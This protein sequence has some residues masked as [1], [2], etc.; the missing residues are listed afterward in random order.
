MDSN[1][2]ICRHEDCGLILEEPVTLLCGN[3]LCKHHLDQCDTKF[4]CNFCHKMHTIPEDGFLV[5]KAFVSIIE[6]YIKL[7]PLKNE[8]KKSFDK[9]S[10]SINDYENLDQDIYVSDYFNNLKQKVNLHKEELIKEITERCEEVIKELKDKQEKCKSS[11]NI[12]K[13]EKFDFYVLKNFILTNLKQKFRAPNMNQ[14]DANELLSIM[15]Q[16]DEQIESHFVK[17]KSDLLLGESIEFKM[18]DKSSSFG[19]LVIFSN[20]DSLSNNCGQLIRCIDHHSGCI[21]SIQVDEDSNKMITGS[22]DKTIKIFDLKSGECLKTLEDHKNWVTSILMIPNSKFISGSW[23]K[24]MKIWDLNS[25]ECLSTLDNESQI[26]SLCLLTTNKIACGCG[27]GTINIW[28]LSNLLRVKSFKAHSDWIP[29]MLVTDNT[30][31]LVSCSGFKDKTIKIWNSKTFE[32]IKELAAH[33]N[34][35]FHIDS[36][37]N[38]NLLSSSY[39][40]SVKLWRIETGELLKSIQFEHPIYFVKMLNDDLMAVGIGNNVKGEIVLYN[41]SKSSI[42]KIISAHSSNVYRLK[43]LPNGDI[44]SGSLNGEIKMWKICDKK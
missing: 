28:S 40:K 23:D 31:L 8:I 18:Y 21:R 17:Y 22:C 10:Q 24:K 32:L 1:A 35:I 12:V 34:A 7:D 13:I 37:S 30:N 9:L 3:N 42:V 11:S 27:D 39:D 15:K 36:I 41:L 38:G 26:F 20:H 33:T 14:N 2:L 44:L 6:N 29:Y 19:K 43:L 16:I 25:Y 4:K 5:N